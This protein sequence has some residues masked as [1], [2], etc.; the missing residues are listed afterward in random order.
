MKSKSPR[1]RLRRQTLDLIWRAF[2]WFRR[3]TR[4]YLRG[5]RNWWNEHL[6]TEIV[7]YLGYAS[8]HHALIAGR[9]VKDRSITPAT[10]HATRWRNL[11]NTYKRFTSHEIP[12]A[13]VRA[14]LAANS[15]DFIS[16]EEGYFSGWLEL[17]GGLQSGWHPVS[18]ELISPKASGRS[19]HPYL[20]KVLVP[21]PNA[22]F[23]VISD[24][25][26]TVMQTHATR[27][28]KVLYTVL[29][30]NAATRLPFKGVA[31]FYQALQRGAGGRESNPLFYVSSSPW[32]LYG[33]LLEFLELERIP[34]GPLLLR[35]W[36]ASR[37][38]AGTEHES[39]KGR[40]IRGILET[41]PELPFILIGDSG[42]E[43][44]EI[45]KNV[46]HEYRSRILAVYIREVSGGARAGAIAG[47][48]G[49]VEACG[50]T[51][52]LAEDTLA[53]AEHAA[54]RGWIRFEDV[55]LVASAKEADD[56][57]GMWDARAAS[58]DGRGVP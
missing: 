48:A 47:L 30:S 34:L 45:Y 6:D 8:K 50:S 17:G 53:A 38:F 12:N 36:G 28:L 55:A 32:N 42:Q 31:A 41:Y 56:R 44:P 18:F 19:A 37:K 58:V 21:P 5:T 43:D 51:L 4:L 27:W 24:I 16:N 23:G 46:V 33:L 15:K 26:D 22:S 7:P 9:V 11:V 57:R 3:R 52:V 40:S 49:E 29:V 2:I 1:P 54:A 20:G 39:H 10:P 14:S 13:R 35:D 25:D